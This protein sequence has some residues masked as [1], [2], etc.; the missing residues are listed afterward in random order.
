[1]YNRQ[2]N[3]EQLRLSQIFEILYRQRWTII[4]V[5][6]LTLLATA[7]YTLTRDK[8]YEATTTIIIKDNNAEQTLGITSKTTD[9]AFRDLQ[10]E[11]EVLKSKDLLKKVADKITKQLY[12]ENT[13]DTLNI[14]KQAVTTIKT[15][16][17]PQDYLH[18]KIATIL[19]DNMWLDNKEETNVVKFSI[20]SPDP[21]EAAM[22]A[23]AY[24]DAYNEIDLRKSRA[25]ATELR[26]F[27]EEQN[28][29][30]T[31]RLSQS[32]SA[33][34]SYLQ[35]ASIKELDAETSTLT[36][37]VASLESE[38]EANE[39]DYK[40]S[41]FLLEE[42]KKELNKLSPKVTKKITAVDD[43]YITELQRMI[44]KK[45]T[46]RDILK[47][48]IISGSNYDQYNLKLKEINAA[49]DSL[50]ATLT[51]RSKSYVASSID[52]YSVVGSGSADRNQISDLSSEV[53]RLQTKIESL[54]LT[55]KIL[56]E[57]LLKYESRMN[58][59][60]TQTIE[61]AQLQRERLFNEKLY[62]KIGEKYEE[63]LLA[64]RSS[65]GKVNILDRADVPTDPVS[66]NVKFNFLIGILAGIFLGI[67]LAFITYSATNKIHTPR[68]IEVL[69]FKLISIIPKLQI[70]GN[71][72][73]LL[74]SGAKSNGNGLIKSSNPNTQ[75][76]ESYLRLGINLA[77]SF[78]DRNLKS[79]LI[80]S[81]G[82]AAGKSATA[83]NVAI[84]L[85][86][87]GKNVL[88]IDTDIRR[89]VVHKYFNK[90]MS[91]GLTDYLLEQK[92]FH[93]VVKKT[94]VKGLDVITCGARMVNPSLILSSSRMHNFMKFETQKYDFIIYDAPPLNPVTDAIHLA[95]QVD[96]VIL[97]VRAEQTYA[98]ELK[99]AADLLEQVNVK[100]GGI[101]LN[102]FDF[103]NAPF[104][105]GKRYG[106]YTYDEANNTKGL[107]KKRNSKSV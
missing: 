16:N 72:N 52:N 99:R 101:V 78:I 100:V 13:K 22:I 67:V 47:L 68:D 3:E 34:K 96:E 107:F 91:P 69:G 76:Y 48:S 61:L 70:T 98:E 31:Q 105:Y 27:L 90:Q 103:A 23:N 79:L 40:N 24:S 39:L 66:P 29:I 15:R 87:L 58:T 4:I 12:I 33:L 5:F 50:K 73:K 28:R 51:E 106:Y 77:Y 56:Y 1:M 86:N 17:L 85:A 10:T 59:L 94:N 42:Y 20:K 25:N 53:Q 11:L 80:S 30:K 63:A 7:V 60:P 21:R 37:K 93:E 41:K 92:Q 38:L 35:K 9:N 18:N 89:P 46:E 95:K 8:L 43:Q 49:I 14:I 75:A 84:T 82:P 45:E 32:D 19:S 65:F 6:V 97:V 83:S 64:E 62:L 88:L 54:D 81:A 71:G 44:A 36:T 104:S 74:E 102:D 26:L 2:Q 55:K 57:N